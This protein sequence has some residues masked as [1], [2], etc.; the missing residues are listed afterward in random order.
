MTTVI[1]LDNAPYVYHLARNYNMLG[2]QQRAERFDG[3][4]GGR[5]YTR[6]H[7]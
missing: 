2:L 4:L 7:K 1:N 5:G 3:R 6:N